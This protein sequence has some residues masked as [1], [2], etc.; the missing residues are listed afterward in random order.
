MEEEEV[1]EEKED[2]EEQ[3]L[4]E[5]EDQEEEEAVVVEEKEEVLE[6]KAEV[7]EEAGVGEMEVATT[8]PAPQ[9][10]RLLCTPAAA[11]NTRHA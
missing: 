10:G 4:E 8:V 5:K 7:L 11:A 3:V 1:V 6:G 9:A 2:P